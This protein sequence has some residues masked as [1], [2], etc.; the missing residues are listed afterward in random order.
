MPNNGA[1]EEFIPQP[2]RRRL[3]GPRQLREGL[4]G[5]DVGEHAV[6]F[7]LDLG[8]LIGMG[9]DDLAGADIAGNTR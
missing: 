7:H 1:S 5:I 4:W 8:D 9:G 2:S 3:G 6:A